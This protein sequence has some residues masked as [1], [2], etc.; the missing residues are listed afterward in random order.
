MN[1]HKGG[2]RVI[3]EATESALELKYIV[4]GCIIIYEKFTHL[5]T[6]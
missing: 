1:K 5:Y 3:Q 6:V 2:L 4:L